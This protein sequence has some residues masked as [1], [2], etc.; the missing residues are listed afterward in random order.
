MK[1][2]WLN[3]TRMGTLKIHTRTKIAVKNLAIIFFRE[4]EVAPQSNQLSRFLVP[5]L[6]M[7]R[8]DSYCY[9][10]II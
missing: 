3:E 2:K 1:K 10:N 9:D 6:L 4:K 5:N 7:I 8:A